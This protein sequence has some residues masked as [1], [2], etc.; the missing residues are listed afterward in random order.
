MS[1]FWDEPSTP[2]SRVVT[3]ARRRSP[4]SS[5]SPKR[6][7]TWFKPTKFTDSSPPTFHHSPSLAL[8]LDFPALVTQSTSFSTA[9]DY[10]EMAKSL[11]EILEGVS[12]SP[13]ILERPIVLS[14][15]VRGAKRN[16]HGDVKT[17]TKKKRTSGPSTIQ[18]SLPLQNSILLDY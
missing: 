13:Y 1:D 11:R 8:S 2:P 3:K 5:R 10:D 6:P 16:Y 14:P 17:V 9:F 7:V 18:V 15:I 12:K 4:I